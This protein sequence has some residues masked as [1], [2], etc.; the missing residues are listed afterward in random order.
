MKTPY[1]QGEEKAIFEAVWQ[2]ILD[3]SD[4]KQDGM[5]FVKFHI[6]DKKRFAEKIASRMKGIFRD[7]WKED[8]RAERRYKTLRQ[9]EMDKAI[10]ELGDT[11]I[12]QSLNERDAN[13]SSP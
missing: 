6:K 3:H 12:V 8:V 11:I 7:G 2:Y 5:L 9:E 1:Y 13:N 4:V 10:A